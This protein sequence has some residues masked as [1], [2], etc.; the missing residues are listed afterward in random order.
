MEKISES[1]TDKRQSVLIAAWWLLLIAAVFPIVWRQVTVS[2]AWWHVALGK[3]LV[4]KR[5]LPNLACFYFTPYNVGPLVAE[6]RWEWLGDILLHLCHALGG[7]VGIQI[8]V[9][10]CVLGAIF[11]LSR[12][13]GEVRGP[14]MLLL[15]VAVALGTYQLQLA[16]NSVFSLVLYPAL[17]WMGAR[18]SGAPRWREYAGMAGLLV[19]WSC[20]HGS[21][22]LGWISACAL[23]GMRALTG[24]RGG[25][26]MG[27]Q[28]IGLFSAAMALTLLLV[29]FGRPDALH[30]LMTPLD[31]VTRT[32][33]EKIDHPKEAQLSSNPS[34]SPVRASPSLKEWLNSSIWKYDPQVPWS[35]DYWSP[36]DMLPGMR[37]IEAA[38]G[39]ALIALGCAM[40]FRNVSAGLIFAWLG[41][42]FL[43]LG[44]VRMFGYTTLA[45]CAVILAATRQL[46]REGWPLLRIGGWVFVGVW[47]A[48]GWCMFATAKIDAF[49]PDGQHVSR[50]GKVPIYDDTTADWVKKAFPEERVFTTIESGS[51]CVSRWNFEKQVFLDGFFAPHTRQVWEAYNGA[52][53][54]GDLAPLHVKFGIQLAI[55]PT[56]SPIWID[57]FRLSPEWNPIAVGAGMVVFAHDSLGRIDGGPR[58]FMETEELR[59]TSFYFRQAALQA[60]FLIASKT[61]ESTAGFQPMEWTSHPSF[62]ALQKMAGEV[63]TKVE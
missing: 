61:P 48:C 45:S 23:Y 16:R 11:F 1:E 30:F 43:G 31:H 6:L 56:T 50:M 3:W 33:V 17:L 55:I 54:D 29:A 42:L 41:S 25:F 34:P 40:W 62:Q 22:V 59:R 35:N 47:I 28:S 7:A 26:R 58:I 18:K 9:L 39:L 4:E 37:P 46:P 14:W 44:Y 60:L 5:S 15:M 36:L 13:A 63:F 20:L 53:N 32:V 21:C 57:R 12:I 38:Y 10:S 52:L 49:I 8:A 27:L 24:F 51:Y 19:L 2:D